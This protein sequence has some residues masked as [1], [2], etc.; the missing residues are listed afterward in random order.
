MLKRRRNHASWVKE[1]NKE[2]SLYSLLSFSTAEAEKVW[3]FEAH[4]A[5]TG[6]IRVH[7]I[8]RE[9]H[10]ASNRDST[11]ELAPKHIGTV[12]NCSHAESQTGIG[13]SLT[14]SPKSQNKE[15]L[16]CDY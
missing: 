13:G 10:K 12:Q 9:G 15:V 14:I 1:V 6:Q 3:I 4:A 16:L 2:H 11:L 8:R 7:R 5:I